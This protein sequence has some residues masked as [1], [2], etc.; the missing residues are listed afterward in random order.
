MYKNIKTIFV[1]KDIDNS[2]SFVYQLQNDLWF[3]PKML[4][5][6]NIIF[7]CDEKEGDPLDIIMIFSNIVND[8][9]GSLVDKLGYFESASSEPYKFV[10]K[11]NNIGKNFIFNFYDVDNNAKNVT[12]KIVIALEFSD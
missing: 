8:I 4:K 7:I 1:S 10:L 3:E 2:S 11:N 12:G 6:K 9:I 5:V